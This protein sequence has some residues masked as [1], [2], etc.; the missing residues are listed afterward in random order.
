MSTSARA[1]WA[2]G[3]KLV[4][5]ASFGFS[6]FS[7]MAAASGIFIEP[8]TKEFGW[9]RTLTSSGMSIAAIV[10]AIL[11]PFAGMLI[12]R[13]GARR[14]ALPGLVLT[15]V[16]MCSFALL[17]GSPWQWTALWL[18]YG[19]ISASVKSTVWTTAVAGVFDKE[20]GLALGITLSG[21]ALAQTITPPLA[22]WLIADYGWRM[23]YVVLA[24]VWGGLAVLLSWVWL[25]DAHDRGKAKA[26]AEGKAPVANLPGLSLAQAWRDTALWRIAIT[27]FF[28]MVLTIGLMVHVFQILREAGVSRENAA[29]LSSLSGIFGIIGKLVTG[30]LLDRFRPN[31]VGGLTLGS[32][33]LAFLFLHDDVRSP[34]VIALA[35]IVN[36]YSAGT[37][38]QIAGYLTTRYG[39]LKNF[40]AIF[41]VI[42]AM[43]AAGSGLGPVFAGAI[44]DWAGNYGP[45][46]I[47]GAV[48]SALCGLLILSLQAYPKWAAPTPPG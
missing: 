19:V 1:E 15:I 43:I 7:I 41:G 21:T 23:A 32:T 11:S 4:V 5:A 13:M 27:T 12:D 39:G 35:M 42:A 8:L 30:W 20:R 3:W 44:Y 9:N 25:Y 36:G 10:S 26:V 28:M 47:A 33:C 14:L 46:L 48:G 31:W 38:I 16:S 40:G 34:W 2:E 45:F 29:W 18:V 24:L 17:T 22:N 37:K 6:F